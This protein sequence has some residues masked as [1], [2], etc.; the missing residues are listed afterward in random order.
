MYLNI[1]LYSCS[2][3]SGWEKENNLANKMASWAKGRTVIAS[4]EVLQTN[5]VNIDSIYPLEVR[6]LDEDGNKDITYVV[7]SGLK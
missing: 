4:Q 7:S 2:T 1:F 3:G 5:R 6:L